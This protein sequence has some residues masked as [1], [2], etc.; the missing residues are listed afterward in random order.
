MLEIWGI[1]LCHMSR[2]D[3]YVLRPQIWVE[4]PWSGTVL[5]IG[6]YNKPHYLCVCV[7]LLP[8]SIFVITC[9]AFG[10]LWIAFNSYNIL[11]FNLLD[12]CAS[13][14]YRA[15]HKP[16][17]VGV[18]VWERDSKKD[19]IFTTRSYPSLDSFHLRER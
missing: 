6:P 7:L 18:C 9:F 19:I 1:C 12:F 8:S 17:C 16:L 14:P 15:P 11:D 3:R 2:W 5:H 10:V 13:K 4:T